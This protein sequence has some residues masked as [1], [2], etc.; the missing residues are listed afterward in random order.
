VA[1]IVDSLIV[2]G[3]TAFGLAALGPTIDCNRRGD[4]TESL[5]P[6]I[7]GLSILVFAGTATSA[8]YGYYQTNRCRS[9]RTNS[10]A[11]HDCG[12]FAA[13]APAG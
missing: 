9:D 1:P 4:C 8:I 13:A 3:A 2:G 12:P 6:G 11:A 10:C 5:A 7:L